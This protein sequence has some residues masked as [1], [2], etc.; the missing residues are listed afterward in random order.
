MF[1]PIKTRLDLDGTQEIYAFPNG[2]GASVVNHRMAY[3]GL[4]LAVTTLEGE[5]PDDFSL[6]YDTPITDDVIGHLNDET[7]SET[8]QAISDLPRR[9]L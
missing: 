2:Y 6:T 7:L 3:G 8:L 5:D 1:T 4:E 9:S